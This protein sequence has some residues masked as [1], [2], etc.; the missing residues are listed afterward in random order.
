MKTDH[1]LAFAAGVSLALTP[2]AATPA[3]PAAMSASMAHPEDGIHP[4]VRCRTDDRGHEVMMMASA[5]PP[6]PPPPPAPPPPVMASP[7]R[8]APADMAMTSPRPQV[9][10]YEPVRDTERYEGEEVSDVMRVADSP[11]STFSADVD[12]ASYSNAR[13][14]LMDGN[15]P[16]SASVRTEEFLNYFRY[17]YPLPENR[18]QPFSVSLDS[19]ITPW[20]ID[21][22]LMRVGI[23]GYDLPRADRPVANLTFLIDVSGSMSSGDKID[24]VRYSLKQLAERLRPDDRVSIVVYAGA[25]GL[26]LE[27]TA[28]KDAVHAALDCMRAGGSTAGAAGLELAYQTARSSFVEGGIN[29]V[30][31]ATDGDFNVGI[32]QDDR[33]TDFIEAQRDS[34]ITLTVLGY[35]RGNLNDS[36]MEKLT[37]AG[38]GNY[39]YVDSKM[40]ADKILGQELSST[41]FTIAGDV[42]FQVEFNPAVIAEYRL[43]GYENRA[44]AEEDFDNDAVDAG[45][46]GAGHQVTALYEV[47]L[48]GREGWLPERRYGEASPRTPDWGAEAAYV[49]LRYKLPGE[50]ESRLLQQPLMASELRAAAVPVGDFAFQAA[51]AAFGQKLRGDEML[52]RFSYGHIRGLAGSQRG[53]DP[54]RQQFVELVA[55]ASDQ[56]SMPD[57]A[58]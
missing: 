20:N 26:V 23:R 22:H 43:I 30:I 24:L 10:Q 51:V 35:G 47:V 21:T 27:P 53:A 45:D 11:V 1:L 52:A 6:S 56:G 57:G 55:L 37:N 39:G 15:M 4:N 18:L 12:T 46:I 28:D 44:L 14:F 49:K 32:T 17:D 13:R 19:A 7:S 41:L 31:L 34:G 8:M 48:V 40:E 2:T 36:M 16:P 33:L 3:L 54:W 38:N 29:R 58:K 9:L 5:P 25:S 42:K 50:D